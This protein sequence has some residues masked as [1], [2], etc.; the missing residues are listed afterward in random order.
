MAMVTKFINFDEPLTEEQHARLRAL[1]DR[2]IVCDEDCPPMTKE[3]CDRLRYLIKKYNTRIITQEIL[4][5]EAKSS[6]TQ[7]A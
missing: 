4:D 7:T 2:P 1:K 5:M 6:A 3:E